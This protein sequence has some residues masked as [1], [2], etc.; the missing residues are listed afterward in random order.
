MKNHERDLSLPSQIFTLS[1][2]KKHLFS[3]REGDT[4]RKKEVVA[5][6]ITDVIAAPRRLYRLVLDGADGMTVDRST[7]DESGYRIGSDLTEE[8][9]ER[10]LTDSATRRAK[11]KALFLLGRRDYARAELQK[12]LEQEAPPAVA[13]GVAE[14]LTELGLLDDAA[15]ARRLARH[16]SE[17]KGYPRRRVEQELLRRGIEWELAHRA[18]AEPE[19]DDTQRAVTL[20]R[21][22]YAGKIG[23]RDARQRTAAAL[24]R[25]GFSYDT[26]RQALEAVADADEDEYAG[27]DGDE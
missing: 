9:L 14:R 27:A 4:M 23:D 21:K 16:L 3:G 12:K 20:I 11:E 8:Q 15:Y 2:D 6:L 1:V 17:Y 13:A 10:L 24:V 25:R 26:V 19:Q 18:A 22:K 7:F 5:V